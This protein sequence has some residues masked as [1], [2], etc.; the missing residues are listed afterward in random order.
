MDK[1]WEIEFPSLGV[2]VTFCPL[3]G[4]VS[5]PTKIVVAHGALGG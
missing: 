3:G 1:Y 4:P 5:F 2:G